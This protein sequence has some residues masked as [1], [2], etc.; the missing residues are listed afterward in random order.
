M[1]STA[2]PNAQ[3]YSRYAVKIY[4]NSYMEMLH[5]IKALDPIPANVEYSIRVYDNKNYFMRQ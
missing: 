2:A 5:T 1:I 4:N 3:L